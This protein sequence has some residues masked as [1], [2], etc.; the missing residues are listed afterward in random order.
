MRPRY[1]VDYKTVT[2]MEWKCC[3]GYSGAD[4]TIGPPGGAGTHVSNGVGTG[5]ALG[6]G[7]NGGRQD[8][9][10]IRKLEEKIQR[11]TEKLQDF[12]STMNEH[13]RHEPVK[14]GKN[15]ADAAPP[16][17]KETI[18]SIQTKLDQLDNRTKAG[19]EDLRR[20]QREDQERIRALEKQLN[21]ADV[22]YQQD[23]ERLQQEVQR[24]QRCC[25]SIG[26]LQSRIGDAENKISSASENINVLLKRLEPS[27]TGGTNNGG[28]SKGG[29][30]AG[31]EGS[32]E[33][34]LTGDGLRNLLEDL[35]LHINSS[36]HRTE[37]ICSYL[38]KDLK[39]YIHK[40]LDDLRTVLS[41]R[42]D[43]RT[44]RIEDVELEVEQVQKELVDH[45][46]RLSE[47]ENSTFEMSRRMEECGCRGHEGGGGG[48]GGAGEAEGGVVGTSGGKGGA[49]EDGRGIFGTGGGAEG[50]GSREGELS[51][52]RENTTKKSLEWRVIANE[53]QIRHFNT[54]LKDLSVSGD[55]LHDRV[56]P[57]HLHVVLPASGHFQL[58]PEP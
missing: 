45:D 9:E 43:D 13:F 2:E 55:S 52:G 38:E 26:D 37:Q 42:F 22:R 40:E 8:S 44:F 39:D 57:D 25:D 20:Q 54:R 47:L 21:A 41:D 10:E 28:E 18:H 17:I 29:G 30:L 34:G 50:E 16:E 49:G 56:S 46:K 23:I 48:L 6:T 36:V 32:K 31:G 7:Q 33:G 4:C 11:L 14:P 51:G 1:K 19:V 15:P 53:G 35:E 3:H 5:S 12:Q 24:S 58:R 27:R